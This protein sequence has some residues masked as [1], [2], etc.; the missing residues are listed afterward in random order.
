[1]NFPQTHFVI[2]IRIKTSKPCDLFVCFDVLNIFY[3]NFPWKVIGRSFD[4]II[5][6]IHL[7]VAFSLLLSIYIWPVPIYQYVH[8]LYQKNGEL[9]VTSKIGELWPSLGNKFDLE[10]G[11]GQGRFIVQIEKK[12]QIDHAY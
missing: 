7:G 4:S 2:S 10:I 5:I 3:F 1:M 11:H 9:K 8:S 12:F 6:S